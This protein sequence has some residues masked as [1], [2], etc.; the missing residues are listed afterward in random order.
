MSN[1]SPEKDLDRAKYLRSFKK[2][3]SNPIA[4][5]SLEDAAKRLE[6]KAAKK[7]SRVGR[8]NKKKAPPS[9]SLR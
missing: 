7:L 6:A 4:I 2:G 1:T 8:P 5:R 3:L 9:V